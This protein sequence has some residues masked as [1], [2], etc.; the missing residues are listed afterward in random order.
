MSKTVLKVSN[1][2]RHY[3]LPKERLFAEPRFVYALNGVSFEIKEGK[4]FGI[5]GESGCGKSTL[6][7]NVMALENTDSGSVQILGEEVV[8]KNFNQLRPLRQHFQMI[9]QDPYGSLDPHHNVGQIVSEPLAAIGKFAANEKNKRVVE[10]LS[11]VGLK[12]TDVEKYP[13]EFSGGQR[14]RIAIARALITKPALIVADEPV[15]ALDVSVQA[16]VL[17]LLRDLQDSFGVTYMFISHDLAV[18][19]YLCDEVAVMY[20]GTIVE[21]GRTEDLFSSPA[22]PYTGILLDAVP[23]PV[24]GRKRKRIQLSG[25]VTG[26]T[27]KRSGCAFQDRCPMVDDRCKR[28]TPLL[29]EVAPEH[30]AACHFSEK[31]MT[32]GLARSS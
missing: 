13:H 25:S 15:S 7:R 8:G 29:K 10:V 19:E 11:S 26:Q 3:P 5:V 30:F 2:V 12:S 14:Q 17:N 21:K 22:H 31:M 32:S 24:P 23:K 1:L 18:V 16:Q 28:E 9:F 4:S 6:A 20:L 27:E